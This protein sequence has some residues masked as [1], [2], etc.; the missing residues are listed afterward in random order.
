MTTAD[1]ASPSPPEGGV[2]CDGR[3]DAADRG[4]LTIG[5]GVIRK[6]AEHAADSVPDTAPARRRSARAGLVETGTKVKVTTKG[7]EVDLEVDLA[8]RYPVAV[9]TAVET[10]R[11]RIASELD[12]AVAMRVRRFRAT[13]SAFVPPIQPRVR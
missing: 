4:S 3:V 1:L 12:H 8:F 2:V 7:D 10:V 6:L 9:R 11:D 5:Q 13:V